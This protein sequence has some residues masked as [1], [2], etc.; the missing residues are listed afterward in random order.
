MT[1]EA[2]EMPNGQPCLIDT[3]E[4][5]ILSNMMQAVDEERYDEAVVE[6]TLANCKRNNIFRVMEEILEN[7]LFSIYTLCT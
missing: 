5:D 4:F 3:V 7:A 6:E 2:Q 1:L